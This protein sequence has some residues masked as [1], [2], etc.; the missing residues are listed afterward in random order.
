MQIRK[1][2]TRDIFP[3]SRIVAKLDLVRLSKMVSG[4][5]EQVGMLIVG[6]LADRLADMEGDLMPFL[7]D[8]VG[9]TPEEFG[10]LPLGELRDVVTQLMAQPEVAG[11][12]GSAKQDTA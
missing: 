11:F 5:A 9:I 8:L 1:L 12:F 10:E 3:L 2:K 4:D 6:L 7:G